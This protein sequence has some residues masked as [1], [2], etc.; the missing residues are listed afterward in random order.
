MIGHIVFWTIKPE[1]GG[2]TA[3]ENAA[4]MRAMLE[5]LP[6]AIDVIRDFHVST[7]IVDSSMAVD[8]LLFSTFDSEADLE[9]YQRHPEHQKCVEFVRQVVA[10]R[11]VVDYSF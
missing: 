5:A 4:T 8:V 1:A 3:A 11:H 7:R 2:K 6:E 9:T 10:S